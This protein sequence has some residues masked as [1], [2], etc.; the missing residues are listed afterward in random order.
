M[1]AT[2]SVRSPAARPN[3]WMR[4]G[5][6]L[7][8]CLAGVLCFGVVL[9]SSALVWLAAIWGVRTGLLL[10]GDPAAGVVQVVLLGSAIA[11]LAVAYL[12]PEHTVLSANMLSLSA[13]LLVFQLG[14]GVAGVLWR[15]RT[16][17]KV[18]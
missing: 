9:G 13:G 3:A 7:A 4:H 1:L 10:P 11:N 15:G 16:P 17:A 5:L 6:R 8:A 12:L 14:A 2:V 18:C